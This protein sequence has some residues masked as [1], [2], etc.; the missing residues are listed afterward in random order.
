M[1]RNSAFSIAA[2]SPWLCSSAIWLERKSPGGS[3]MM[4]KVTKLITIS[5][6]IMISARRSVYLSIS[7]KKTHL[8][9]NVSGR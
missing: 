8:N 2:L 7:L 4:T 1:R 5:V 6:G 9:Q 3:W